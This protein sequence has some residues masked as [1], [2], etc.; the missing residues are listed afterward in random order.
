MFCDS[1]FKLCLKAFKYTFKSILY[2]KSQIRVNKLLR[3]VNM[4]N[5]LYLFSL[6]VLMETFKVCDYI[7]NDFRYY[8][9]KQ[10]DN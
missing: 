2:L 3:Y 1:L 7:E 6:A 4:L 9:G 10:F 5:E 8:C